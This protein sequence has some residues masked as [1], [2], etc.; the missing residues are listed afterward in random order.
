M[1]HFVVASKVG[2]R[3]THMIFSVTEGIM[4]RWASALGSFCKLIFNVIGDWLISDCRTAQLRSSVA[5]VLVS[6]LDKLI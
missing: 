5:R 6:E 2:F 4:R 3:P 1:A